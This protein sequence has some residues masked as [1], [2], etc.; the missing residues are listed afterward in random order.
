MNNIFVFLHSPIH[1]S[2]RKRK[3]KLGLSFLTSDNNSK[4]IV[5]DYALGAENMMMNGAVTDPA[6][7]HLSL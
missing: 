5:C 7:K 6:D 2:K 3:N 1:L 4:N